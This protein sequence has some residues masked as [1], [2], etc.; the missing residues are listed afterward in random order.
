MNAVTPIAAAPS[1]DPSSDRADACALT[2]AE[3]LDA[4]MA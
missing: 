3:Q 2:L 1:P 4:E